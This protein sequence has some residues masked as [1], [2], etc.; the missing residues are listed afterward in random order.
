MASDEE[1]LQQIRSLLS[2]ITLPPWET[3]KNKT[4]GYLNMP[5]VSPSDSENILAIG[6]MV[7]PNQGGPVALSLMGSP[8]FCGNRQ[9]DTAEQAMRNADFIAQA[10]SIIKFLLDYIDT[11]S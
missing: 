4:G 3:P 5:V 2:S 7:F 10:P 6:Y 9:P 11:H 1:Y 8:E